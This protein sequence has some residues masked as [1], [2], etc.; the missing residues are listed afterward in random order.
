[1]TIKLLGKGLHGRVTYIKIKKQVD[2]LLVTNKR[3][4]KKL[5]KVFQARNKHTG[6]DYA[7]KAIKKDRLHDKEKNRVRN[8]KYFIYNY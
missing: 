8:Y 1:M 6:I 4:N 2:N 5:L 3:K 7:V